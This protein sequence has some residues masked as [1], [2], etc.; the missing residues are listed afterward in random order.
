MRSL[1]VDDAAL[2]GDL[3]GKVTDGVAIGVLPGE[4]L[5][6]PR[7]IATH[8]A[9]LVDLDP[10]WVDLNG[11]LVDVS[12]FKVDLDPVWVDLNRVLVGV[13]AF[14]VDLDPVWVDLNRVLVDVSAFKV[15]LFGFLAPLAAV[16]ASL[17]AGQARSAPGV[18]SHGA[19]LGR[20][21]PPRGRGGA[22]RGPIPAP[23]SPAAARSASKG[24]AADQG[25]P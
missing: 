19:A 10:V 20:M 16:L 2:A 15:D 23:F 12:A 11:V 18:L 1:A 9:A 21:R 6:F 13:N 25:A 3:A 7:V 8:D 14:K 5:A 22:S 4:K 17:D 24:G